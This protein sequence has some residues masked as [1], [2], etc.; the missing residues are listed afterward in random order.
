MKYAM[1]FGSA[2]F[3]L[4]A[5]PALA[6]KENSDCRKPGTRCVNA[7]RPAIAYCG[8]WNAKDALPQKT[9][10]YGQDTHI[11]AP[12]LV[13][14]VGGEACKSDRDCPADKKCARPNSTAAWR[15]VIAR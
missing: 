2:M 8:P 14:G 1:F 10:V 4:A 5:L 6:C 15:C 3:A 11:P 9:W 12:P 13:Q 7:H